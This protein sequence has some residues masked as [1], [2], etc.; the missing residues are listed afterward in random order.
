MA[1]SDP[2]IQFM[3]RNQELG[4]GDAD[5]ATETDDLPTAKLPQFVVVPLLSVLDLGAYL[6]NTAVRVLV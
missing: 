6:D 1:D 4:Q 2:E 5:S 3:N